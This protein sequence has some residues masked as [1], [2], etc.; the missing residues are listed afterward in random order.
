MKRIL[1]L[2]VAVLMFTATPAWAAETRQ[3]TS[4]TRCGD[5][6]VVAMFEIVNNPESVTA[7]W[8]NPAGVLTT[9]SPDM[10][11]LI[12]DGMLT[13]YTNRHTV[14]PGPDGWSFRATGNGIVNDYIGNTQPI[15]TFRCSPVKGPAWALLP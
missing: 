6:W 7:R 2:A 1:I 5:Q 15:F 3:S 10:G 11:V 4:T 12:I 9:Y 13:I 14:Q 8:Y